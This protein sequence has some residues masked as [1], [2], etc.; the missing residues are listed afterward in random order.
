VGHPRQHRPRRPACDGGA[1]GC[2][3]GRESSFLAAFGPSPRSLHITR[4][5]RAFS[6]CCGTHV[7]SPRKVGKD[8][9]PGG[10][11]PLT[12]APATDGMGDTGGHG[13]AGRARAARDQN[14][15]ASCHVEFR[16]STAQRHG[17]ARGNAHFAR[18]R[19]TPGAGRG[20]ICERDGN[21]RA[22]GAPCSGVWARGARMA[23]R[24]PVRAWCAVR[25]AGE[26]RGHVPPVPV[27]GSFILCTGVG[28]PESYVTCTALLT[29]VC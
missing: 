11:T 1:P 13:A 2:C 10:H 28:T 3:D 7:G 26:R 4:S 22:L 29:P 23:R 18:D 17:T 12:T 8:R 9:K 24:A 14:G 6:A 19:Y 20:A 21:V 16:F 5:F 25:P 27:V 15:V